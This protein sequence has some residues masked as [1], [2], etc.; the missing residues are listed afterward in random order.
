VDGVVAVIPPE[1]RR[2]LLIGDLE[3]AGCLTFFQEIAICVERLGA[4]LLVDDPPAVVF[5]QGAVDLPL[6]DES[7]RNLLPGGLVLL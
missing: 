7:R 5:P 2:Q 4:A 3:V 1:P 6:H